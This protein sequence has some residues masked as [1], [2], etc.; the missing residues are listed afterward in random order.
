MSKPLHLQLHPLL[1]LPC[2]D[3]TLS[4]FEEK[5]KTGFEKSFLKF[6]SL[7]HTFDLGG[8]LRQR[9]VSLSDAESDHFLCP[10]MDQDVKKSFVIVRVRVKSE[11]I[12]I[13]CGTSFQNML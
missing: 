5:K 8:N 1:H 2:S 13:S 7:S 11:R 9:S 12:P 4:T 3:V 10:T 6:P